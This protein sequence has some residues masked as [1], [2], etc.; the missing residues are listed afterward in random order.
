MLLKCFEEKTSSLENAHLVNRADFQHTDF[1]NGNITDW[2]SREKVVSD[3]DNNKVSPSSG[4]EPNICKAQQLTTLITKTR[5]A[6]K[7]YEGNKKSLFKSISSRRK[8]SENMGLLQGH[9]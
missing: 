3:N 2:I 1:H 8:N 5:R 9:W 6:E 4:R 7:E